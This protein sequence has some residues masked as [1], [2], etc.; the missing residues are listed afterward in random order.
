MVADILKTH[1][2]SFNP[3][4]YYLYIENNKTKDT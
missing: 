2:G 1:L 3:L 4:I